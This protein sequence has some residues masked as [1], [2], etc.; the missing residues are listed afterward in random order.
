MQGKVLQSGEVSQQQVDLSGLNLGVY[1]LTLTDAQ[2]Q[3]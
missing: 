3:Q 2:V 1:I